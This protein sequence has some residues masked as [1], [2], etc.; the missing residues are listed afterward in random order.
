MS[1]GDSFTSVR[2]AMDAPSAVVAARV[3]LVGY[4]RLSIPKS[5]RKRGRI[6]LYSTSRS[7]VPFHGQRVDAPRIF[8]V[9]STAWPTAG[10]DGPPFTPFG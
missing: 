1:S 7:T 8:I 10:A 9:S 3:T 5:S 6:V 4:G 2:T